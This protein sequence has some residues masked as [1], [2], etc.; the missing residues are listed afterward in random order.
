M[1]KSGW[2]PHVLLCPSLPVSL[3]SLSDSKSPQVSRTLLSILT[4]LNNAVVWMV[5]YCPLISK[6]SCLF[7]E[8]EWM[9]VSSSLRTLLSILLLIM[10]YS[11]WFPLVLWCPSLPISL[12]SLNDSKSLQDSRTLLSFLSVLYNA[13]VWMVSTCP[14]MSKSSSLFIEFEWQQVSSSLQDSSQHSYRS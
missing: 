11:G 8:F 10:L 14:L 13:V 9:Q 4:V 2:F 7:I 12:L 1:R 5:S 3:S 6:S